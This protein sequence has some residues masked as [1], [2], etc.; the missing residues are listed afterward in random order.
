MQVNKFIQLH[1]II[2]LWGFTPVLGKFISFGALD[3]VWYRLAISLVGLLLFMWYIKQSVSMDLKSIIHIGTIGTIVG[4]HWYFF[5]YAIKVSNVSVTMAGFSTL[6][7]F[8]SLLQPLL[9]KKKFFW[10][11]FIYGIILVIGLGIIFKFETDQLA[12]I[13]YGIL[14]ALTGA[15]FGVYNGKLIAMHGAYKI[16]FYE[17]WGA[18]I[19]ITL[20]KVGM[21]FDGF[22]LPSIGLSDG[23]GL[24]IL[25]ILCTI[26]AFTWSIEILKHFSP[27]TVII[28]NNLE[29]VYG[30]IFSLLLFGDTEYM[31]SGFY[32]GAAIILISVFTYPLI[33]QRFVN[34]I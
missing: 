10:G 18:L 12:G 15:F 9:L 13:V 22:Q 3:L 24:L 5:Y 6:T 8:A 11:D 34:D 29:P 14:A 28:T 33:K 1:I 31:S 2:L 26:V 19:F 7:L 23:I 27:L 21:D 25:S 16:T 4:L 32:V 30:I 17:F 20:V